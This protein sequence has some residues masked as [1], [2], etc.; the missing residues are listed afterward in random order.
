MEKE[1]CLLESFPKTKPATYRKVNQ[2][3]PVGQ[4]FLLLKCRVA[5]K[6]EVDPRC[7][8]LL[9]HLG[10]SEVTESLLPRLECSSLISAYCNLYLPGSSSY[11]A[12]SSRTGF[13]HVGQVGFELLTA[14]NPPASASQS[15]GIMGMSHC[16]WPI[17]V[18]FSFA[19][20]FFVVVVVLFFLFLRWSLAPSLRLECSGTIPAHYSLCLLGSKMGFCHV[21]QAGLELLMSGDPPSLASQSARITGVSHGA[22]APKVFDVKL[23]KVSLTLLIRL[24]CSGMISAHCNLCLLGL[25]NSPASASLVAG[26]T[27]VRHHAQLIFFIFS[28]DGVSP[29]W[30]G[31]S[32]TPDL[33]IHLPWPPKVLGLQSLYHAGWSAVAQ[34]QLTAL[35]LLDS[36]DS[37][38]SLMNSWDYRRTPPR[39]ANF[40]SRVRVPPLLTRLTESRS[41]AQARVQWH[42]LSS[43]QPP[44]SGYKRSSCLSPPVAQITGMC[45]HA[46]LIF[47]FLVEMG[48][49]PVGQAGLNLLT[50]EIESHYVA[51]AGLEL[52]ASEDPPAFTSLC[53]GITVEIGFLH[54]GQSGLELPTSGDPSGHVCI[55]KN[56]KNHLK[57]PGSREMGFLH[58]GQAGLKLPTS[59][60]P[61]ASASQSA[62]IT[63]GV[64]P[65]LP[66]LECN[67]AI[68]AHHNFCLPDSSD[69]PASASQ[70]KL[71]WNYR[72]Q[73]IHPPWPPKAGAQWRILDYC[74]LP[75]LGS[76]HSRASASQRQDFPMLPR[77]VLGLRDPPA[78]A[79]CIV[80]TI[81]R[82]DKAGL[83][84]L[85]SGDPPTSAFQNLSNSPASASPVAGTTVTRHQAWLIFLFFVETGF[86]HVGQADLERLTSGDPLTSV[87][88]GAEIADNKVY[89]L[90]PMIFVLT[91]WPRLECRG[92]ILAHCSL[93]LQDLSSP[94]ASASQVAG[95]TGTSQKICKA[96]FLIF[97][98]PKCGHTVP[99]GVLLLLPRL[100][101]SGVISA[102]CN[103]CLPGSSYSAS[104]S[105]VAGIIG[106]YH[107]AQLILMRQ[108]PPILAQA[109]VQ[110]CDH[111]SLQLQIAKLKDGVLYYMA[112]AGLKLQGFS[113]LA[114]TGIAGT[115]HY[116]WLI[117][118]FLVDTGLYHVGQAGLKLLT[119][120][121][122]PPQ[123]P[124]VLLCYLDCSSVV[125]SWLTA[126]SSSW[127]HVILLFQP[128]EYLGLQV[129]TATAQLIFLFFETESCS[130]VRLDSG[131]VL[132]HCNLH[133]PGSSNSSTS[134][135]RVAGTTESGFLHV[136]QTGLELQTS[137]DPPTLASQSAG[138]AGISH[139]AWPVVDV[140]TEILA[141]FVM[142][143]SCSVPQAGVQRPSLTV[144]QAGVQWS[145]LS[146][147]KPQPLGFKRFSCLSLPSSWDYKRSLAVLPQLECSS[148]LS[149]H[150]NLHCLDFS[151]SRASDSQVTEITGTCHHT[152]L[153]LRSLAL[154]PRVECSGEISAHCNL[155]LP[156]SSSSPVSSFQ[157]GFHHIDQAGLELLTSVTYPPQSPKRQ[158]FTMLARLVL[159]SRPQVILLPRPPK[160]LGCKARSLAVLPRSAVVQSELIVTS[161]SWVQAILLPQPPEYLRLQVPATMPC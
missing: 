44:P 123:P 68:S 30:L 15:A 117:L 102:H 142:T 157:T 37:C 84:L 57:E 118:V 26:I 7:L 132:A 122:P 146:S 103:L 95:T 65:L 129:S 10:W 115:C 93:H 46:W 32:R 86:H 81:K 19:V 72:P 89:G 91:W 104:A 140:L 71:V 14:S 116:A 43:L 121:D 3:A 78:S 55:L 126:A 29:F 28:R 82:D 109:G 79:S 152:W 20:F 149:A 101:Y 108:N 41:I 125:R 113:D 94:P 130:V 70:V 76:S 141:F 107:H 45:H 2:E 48:F 105:R 120:S 16:A 25:R 61:P 23:V 4:P 39:L 96:M 40:C 47:V 131:A 27:G 21:G 56:D 50:S 49:C 114:L 148:T 17:F 8:R 100:K 1:G 106:M 31:W 80:M 161:A 133:L 159:N 134:A 59:G 150:C 33:M 156:G 153:I 63:D 5:V 135:S 160:V 36:S 35:C 38:L 112:Q 137:G 97:H 99:D 145:D 52:L 110:W 155:Y 9:P 75:F 62:G 74:N 143:E 128:P 69:S 64:S 90:E 34:F 147:L 138:I 144:P 11:H 124:E 54:V 92:A 158:D 12:S 42:D 85:T 73:V 87:S 88:P 66:R 127:A 77:L 22:Q 151:D 13:Y 67:G 18:F 83:E 6:G 58:V 139:H 154:S 119:P 60:D 136:G 98:F 111:G 53:S 24:E 51:Q